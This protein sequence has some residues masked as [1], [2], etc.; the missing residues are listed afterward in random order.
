[1]TTTDRSGV[2]LAAAI[3]DDPIL[4]LTIY[5]PELSYFTGKLEA[6]VR[7]ME[8]PY[9]RIPK[10][11]MGDVARTTESG[12]SKNCGAI[13]TSCPRQTSKKFGADSK[14][15]VAGRRCGVSRV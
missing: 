13:S 2:E 9:Q 3:A 15:R 12:A 14:R 10:G 5:G 11:P 6:V 4:P 8:L 7:Y 1:M